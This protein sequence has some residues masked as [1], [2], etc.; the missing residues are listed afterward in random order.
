MLIAINSKTYIQYAHVRTIHYDKEKDT[1]AF[2]VD[3]NT[4]VSAVGDWR[5]RIVDA[6]KVK[7]VIVYK[8]R[9]ELRS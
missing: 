4:W 6:L 2:L 5:K 7:A 1:T 3:K 8:D 9:Y